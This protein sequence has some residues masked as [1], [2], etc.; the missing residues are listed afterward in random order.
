MR[1]NSTKYM[2]LKPE[3]VKMPRKDTTELI[4]LKCSYY[5]KQSK[6]FVQSLSKFQWYFSKKKNKQ[7]QNLFRTTKYS[8]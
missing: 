6:D 2:Y 1:N 8:K 7:S 3:N 4:L 5:S